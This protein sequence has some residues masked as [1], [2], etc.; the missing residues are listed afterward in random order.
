[1][2]RPSKRL[3][4]I[5]SLSLL[6]QLFAPAYTAHLSKKKVT[7]SKKSHDDDDQDENQEPVWGSFR[8][9]DHFGANLD[10]LGIISGPGIISEPGIISGPVHYR[11]PARRDQNA[12][13]RGIVSLIGTYLLKSVNFLAKVTTKLTAAVE[14]S[15]TITQAIKGCGAFFPSLDE[16]W[17]KYE[18]LDAEFRTISADIDAQNNQGNQSSQPVSQSASQPVSQSA[19]QPVSQSASQPV[20]QSASQPVSQSSQP[21]SQSASQPVSQSASQPVSQSASQPVSQSASQPVSQSAS[22]PVSQSASQPVSQS[23]SQPVS[24]SASQPVSQSA[25][26]PVSQSASQ[27]VS[28]SASQPVSQSASQPVSQSASQPVSQSAS[29]PVSQSASQPVSQSASQ[30]VSQSASQPVSQSAS[31]PVSQSASQPVSQSAS[32]PVSQSASQ[33][34]SQSAS[35]PV[36]Q[37]AS[38]PVSQSAS[39][40]VSQSA[41]QPVSQSA[42]QPV[43]QSASQPVSQSASQPVSQSA[44][45]PVSQSASQPVSQSASQSVSQSATTIRQIYANSSFYEYR[46]TRDKMQSI[47]D[48]QERVFKS[49]GPNVLIALQNASFEIEAYIDGKDIDAD[50]DNNKLTL[51]DLQRNLNAVLHRVPLT[52]GCHRIIGRLELVTR[53]RFTIV[54]GRGRQRQKCWLCV[55]ACLATRAVHLELAWVFSDIDSFLNALTR[56]ISPRGVPKEMVGDNGTNFVG[57]VNQLKQLVNQL[58]KDKVQQVTANK[59]VNWKFNPRGAPHFGGIYEIMIMVKAAKKAMYAEIGN[60][61]VNDE[62][63]ITIYLLI[64]VIHDHSRINRRIP[65]MMSRLHQTTSFM[66]RLYYSSSQR[67]TAKLQICK[68]A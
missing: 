54:Q 12:A 29:Q 27:P 47:A 68:S 44:S 6:L 50:I 2:T 64:F 3:V 11:T 14:L 23:A 55:F 13:R 67:S 60:S 39:Q 51:S 59:D 34:V 5:L 16:N 21:V 40:P 1:M 62:E 35:Q 63:L 33:P 30:P 19:S 41:S 25:S 56:F 65:E 17:K 36:S 18:Q 26:Q 38:Q 4:L 42:S 58:D 52:L 31:Q 37:S 48:E 10:T 9:R 66:D 15:L 53:G 8:V 43:S 7:H 24:Q 61:N 28:Q 32:Q 20:S 57:A 22:Q 46:N 49:L 45:Q